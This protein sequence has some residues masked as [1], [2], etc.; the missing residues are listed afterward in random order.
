MAKTA[1]SEALA[2]V[3]RW[4][5]CKL[6]AYPDPGTGGA[7]W[8]I[9]WGQ[10][11]PG[12]KKGD[13]WTQE[14]AD[15]ALGKEVDTLIEQIRDHF[16]QVRITAAQFG[17]MASLAYNIG[18]GAFRRSTLARKFAAGDVQGAAAEFPRWNKANGRVMRGLVN[19]RADEHRV[20][21]GQE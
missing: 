8:T 5:G 11:G 10:T 20:F 9:G 13:V 12:I 1:K 2:L 6:S 14:Q 7:P 4:E 17:A 18:I 15:R 16:G 21:E 3:K 19:R